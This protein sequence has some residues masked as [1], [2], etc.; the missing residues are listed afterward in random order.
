MPISIGVLRLFAT[1]ALASIAL[2]AAALTACGGHARGPGGEPLPDP[3]ATADLENPA[4]KQIGV[5]SFSETAGG[6]RLGLSVSDLPP[7]E[8]GMHLHQSGS[9][10]PPK[11]ESAGGHFNPSRKKHGSENPDGPHAGDLPNLN[12]RP[13]G[14][15]DTSFT[16]SRDLLGSGPGSILKSGGAAVVIHAKPDDYR[17]DPSGASGD[18]IACG[19]VTRG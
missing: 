19:V 11:F 17:T 13:D 5:A 2:A 9:C 6:A 18:R 10:T 14:S 7:G 3:I 8:H 12:V 1:G 4:G 15:A 16:V